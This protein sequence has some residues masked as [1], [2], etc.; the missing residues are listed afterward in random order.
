[1]NRGILSL[2]RGDGGDSSRPYATAA[3]ARDGVETSAVL[4]AA[5]GRV[6]RL[7]VYDLPPA[8]MTTS[9]SN[10]GSIFTTGG[11]MY[12]ASSNATANGVAIAYINAG[13]GTS[14]MY[15]PNGT[16]AGVVDWTRRRI[17]VVRLSRT[18]GSNASHKMRTHWGQLPGGQT[19]YG[20]IGRGIGFEIVNTRYWLV[21]HNGAVTTSVDSGVDYVSGT[22][23]V[24]AE[25]DGAGNCVLHVDGVQI[26]S[27]TGG[28]VSLSASADS[29]Q[30][31]VSNGGDASNN[32]WQL[33]PPRLTWA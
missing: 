20:S 26:A 13:N 8:G 27:C 32:A 30:I 31:A 1:M 11:N 4:S 16:A 24:M 23:D 28:P 14:A 19:A 3:Q 9:G 10:G 22:V 25:S 6:S 29:L 2:P 5:R 12:I 15:S 21:V 33:G 7:S 17:V 18:A